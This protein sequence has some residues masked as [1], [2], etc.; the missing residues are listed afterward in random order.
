M[1]ASRPQYC[2]ICKKVGQNVSHAARKLTIVFSVTFFLFSNNSWSIGQNAPPHWCLGTLLFGRGV[3]ITYSYTFIP[4]C[5]KKIPSPQSNRNMF[6][7]ILFK[8][9][10]KFPSATIKHREIQGSL[11]NWEE[12]NWP[13]PSFCSSLPNQCWKRNNLKCC[14]NS[15]GEAQKCVVC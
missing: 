2:Q 3:V 15:F 1:G 10:M 4:E 9:H 14:S 8:H 7:N 5:T 12:G 11:S 13:T 6:S